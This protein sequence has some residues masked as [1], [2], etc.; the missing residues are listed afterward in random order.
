MSGT[1][2]I[3]WCVKTVGALLFGKAVGQ[4]GCLSQFPAGVIFT[5]TLEMILKKR[6]CFCVV[7]NLLRGTRGLTLPKALFGGK[8]TCG[9]NSVV[10]SL[11]AWVLSSSGLVKPA[12][13]W[14]AGFNICCE[15]AKFLW[16]KRE[17]IAN[18]KKDAV[19]KTA[20][21]VASRAI[22]AVALT[23]SAGDATRVG[24]RR[25]VANVRAFFDETPNDVAVCVSVAA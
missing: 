15:T 23:A 21:R 6:R 7:L 22:V 12:A 11:A 14:L 24:R 16:S 2:F 9:T 10:C 19:A 13:F 17:R 8:Y 18:C 25:C 20:R 4:I 1:D 3:I 5:V